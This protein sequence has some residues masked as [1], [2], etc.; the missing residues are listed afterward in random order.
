MT[1]ENWFPTPVYYNDLVFDE[2]SPIQQEIFENLERMTLKDLSN[3]FND[4]VKTT[5]KH[6]MI[7][8]VVSEFALTHLYKIIEKCAI[9]FCNDVKYDGTGNTDYKIKMIE[10]WINFYNKN[11][12]QFDHEHTGDIS[13]VYYYQ[14]NAN[15]GNIVFSNPNVSTKLQRFPSNSFSKS[16]Y[17]KPRIGKIVLFP[18]WLTH[19]V[20][21]NKTDDT[22]IS[23]AFNL[24]IS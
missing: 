9:E 14:T 15:D 10:S 16:I 1:V 17:Y 11:D 20:E 8:D 22:R 18:S 13:G 12:Y 4:T 21:P 19:R 6:G 7:N 2:Y 3:P 5:F 24:K 23:I